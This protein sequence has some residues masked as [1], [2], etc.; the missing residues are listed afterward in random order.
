[1]THE[2]TPLLQRHSWAEDAFG[3][4]NGTFLASLGLYLLHTTQAVTGGTAG[5]S[6]LLSYASG[7]PFGAVF[8]AINL[9]FLLLAVH[10]KGWDFTV[11]TLA[12]VAAV[13]AFGPLHAWALPVPGIDGVYAVLVGN[14][15]TGIGM[16]M[17]FRHRSSLGGLNTLVLILQERFGWRAGWVQMGF[18]V[19]IIAS[20]LSV[21]SVPMALLSAA[22]AILL[23]LVLAFNHRP[24]RYLG[25]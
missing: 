18:D 25:Y 14:L 13:S 10:R 4:L 15:L 3:L 22:G 6:L 9:P 11:R 23:N 17:L 20:A 12:S 19:A 7:W 24:E 8:F 1:M 5:L 21:V 16:L 2:P